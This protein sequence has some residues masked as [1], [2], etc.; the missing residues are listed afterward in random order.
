MIP[1][2]K[3]LGNLKSCKTHA[4]CAK[5][6]TARDQE[7]LTRGCT[8]RRT[9]ATHNI[10][11]ITKN[12]L[13]NL[14]AYSC[15]GQD[16][17]RTC[18]QEGFFSTGSTTVRLLSWSPGAPPSTYSTP[19]TIFWRSAADSCPSTLSNCLLL[20]M[21]PVTSSGLSIP[22]PFGSARTPE[23]NAEMW[24]C[25]NPPALVKD[26]AIAGERAL[27]VRG[28]TLAVQVERIAWNIVCWF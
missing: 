3:R 2:P 24:S 1:K 7:P 27:R 19:H 28:R 5:D 6:A 26:S 20:V 10:G 11:R 14:L 12:T 17:L 4:S 8:T 23:H 9:Q 18:P 22:S 25:L 21:V 16:M 15:L 13:C